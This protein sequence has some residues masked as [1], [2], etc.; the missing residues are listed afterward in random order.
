MRAIYHLVRRFLP[1]LF[2]LYLFTRARMWAQRVQNMK[3]LSHYYTLNIE[4]LL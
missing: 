1:R 4:T 2:G 3:I